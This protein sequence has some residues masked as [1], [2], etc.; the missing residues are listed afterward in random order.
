MPVPPTTTFSGDGAREIA[1]RARGTPR[2][3]E[4]DRASTLD[5]MIRNT[6]DA[7]S[8][9]PFQYL[10]PSITIGREGYTQLRER[11]RRIL[12]GFLSHVH[13]RVVA[14]D[15]FGWAEV[16]ADLVVDGGAGRPPSWESEV[17]DT[18]RAWPHWDL[19]LAAANRPG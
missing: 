19:R 13:P 5:R 2:V 16:I 17:D 7:Y 12:A 6:D 8:F 18:A 4:L 11:E 15:T 14:S 3:A 10:A 1:R 9:P